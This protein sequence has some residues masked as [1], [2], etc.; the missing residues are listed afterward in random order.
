MGFLLLVLWV[1]SV[2]K[3]VLRDPRQQPY[4]KNKKKG[5][6]QQQRQQQSTTHKKT[7]KSKQRAP[8]KPKKYPQIRPKKKTRRTNSYTTATIDEIKRCKQ[9]WMDRMHR[10]HMEARVQFKRIRQ[11][12]DARN[13][14]RLPPK[15]KQ[16]PPRLD[17]SRARPVCNPSLAG[18]GR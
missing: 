7:K 15:E 8:D 12:L 3:F 9:L 5:K 14:V 11:E 2:Y 13:L 17:F 4:K 16:T 10:V 6:P 18:I 1:P